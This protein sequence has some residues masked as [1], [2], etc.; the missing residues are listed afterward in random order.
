M[1]HNADSS[2]I[3]LSQSKGIEERGENLP[4]RNGWL[5]TADTKRVA[6]VR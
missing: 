3:V 2:L 1:Y 5:V 6:H 4:R